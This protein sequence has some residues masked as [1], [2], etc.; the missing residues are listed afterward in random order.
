VTVSDFPGLA[1]MSASGARNP[2]GDQRPLRQGTAIRTE[3]GKCT[4]IFIFKYQ[5]R[6]T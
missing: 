3:I 2:T 1:R 5:N 6:M 4:L